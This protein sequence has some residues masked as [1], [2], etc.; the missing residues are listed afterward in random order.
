MSISEPEGDRA[1]ALLALAGFF[2][3]AAFRVCD[4]LLPQ[5][6]TTFGTS[7]GFAAY[8]IT[9]FSVAYGSLQV[10][11]GPLGDR[12]GKYR[13]AA[14]ATFACAIGNIAAVF[15]TSLPALIASRAIAG[16]TGGGIIPLALAWIGDTI[17]YAQR[18]AVLARFLTGTILG[19]AC[20]QFIG[21]LFA[22]TLG[23][24]W[25]FGSLAGCYVIV[26]V[27]LQFELRRLA[28]RS[29]KIVAEET[30]ANDAPPRLSFIAQATEILRDRW[31]RVV[32]ITVAIEGAIVFGALAFVPADLHARFGLSLTVAGG[33]VA[34]Y[35]LGGVGYTLCARRLVA[36]LG[37]R[38]LARIGGIV[39]L[40]AFG[41][42]AL[43]RDWHITIVACFAVGF[44]FYML[45]NT[46][47]TN[48]TQMAPHARGTAVAMFASAFFIGQSIGVALAA[49]IVDHF[50]ANWLF[51][52]ATM[53]MP[54]LATG[55]AHALASRPS[56]HFS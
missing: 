19:I 54:L 4:P 5:L 42:L 52:I 35:G 45:H 26:G 55:F 8:T 22:D 15:A 7:T 28:R 24:R 30:A 50:G 38:G 48:A 23:W 16:A 29:A 12:Y 34:A 21:G 37:E 56:Q 31:A 2:S 41:A 27:L 47:Q 18:Q 44:G 32:L 10:F 14:F 53:L 36:R 11:W 40:L 6:A 43:A 17:P 1:I 13:T 51:L 49:P 9:V 39:T 46:L 20:G 25:A 33:I 3:A